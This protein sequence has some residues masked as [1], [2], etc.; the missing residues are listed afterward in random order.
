MSKNAYL[1]SISQHKGRDK[2]VASSYCFPWWRSW[3]YQPASWLG[4]L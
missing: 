4:V 3:L 1:D 2:A